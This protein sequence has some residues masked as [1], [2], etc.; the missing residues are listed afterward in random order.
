MIFS[1]TVYCPDEE[2]DREID[3][4]EELISHLNRLGVEVTDEIP[5]KEVADR[6]LAMDSSLFDFQK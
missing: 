2:V 3:P 6:V 4:V 1:T 5:H